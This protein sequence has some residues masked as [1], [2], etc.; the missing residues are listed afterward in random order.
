MKKFLIIV[1]AVLFLI[2]CTTENKNESAAIN[3]GVKDKLFS[4]VLNENREI[5]IYDPSSQTGPRALG[6]KKYPVIYLLDGDAHFHSVAGMVRQLSGIC[7]D[8]II[9]AI[10]N[11]D[12]TRD[13][14]HTH[15]EVVFGDST[16][17]K[18]SG[19]GEKFTEFIEKE[20][21]PYVDDKYPTT[22]HRTLIGHSLGGLFTVNTLINHPNLFRNYLAIDPSMW[23]DNRSTLKLLKEK[24]TSLNF[25][26][27][28][29]YVAVANTLDKG[30]DITTV[31]SDTTESSE[32]IRSI[33]EFNKFLEP[34]KGQLN[35]KSGYYPDDNHGSVPFIAEYDALRFMFSWY[36]YQGI[37]QLFFP[38]S[39]ITPAEALEKITSHFKMVSENLGYEILPDEGIVNNIGYG[40]M[41]NGKSDHAYAFFKL[42]VDNFPMSSNVYDSMG[43]YYLDQKDTT[44]AITNFKKALEIEPVPHTKTKLESLTKK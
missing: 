9:V 30:M 32:H 15:V 14:T 44:N 20:L 22:S 37:D 31:E 38:D 3:L 40:F 17:S 26:K 6:K 29:L 25:D 2:G 10:P 27:K 39:K 19:G 11:T 36:N 41:G 33:L 16:F 1:F 12:R 13:L 28:W 5:W 23:W 8:M 21:I 43:D 18:T 34:N 24:L 35:F 7:P 4:K 42:N